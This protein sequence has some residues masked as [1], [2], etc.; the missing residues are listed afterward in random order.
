M[1]AAQLRRIKEK[2]RPDQDGPTLTPQHAT[3]RQLDA[4]ER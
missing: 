1:S 2:G 4:A 3:T